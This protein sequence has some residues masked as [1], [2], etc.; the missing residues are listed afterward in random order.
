MNLNPATEF[1]VTLKNGKAVNV[2]WF[3]NYFTDTDHLELRG[4]M[5]STGY[6]SDFLH[7]EHGVELEADSVMEYARQLAQ[8]CWEENTEKYGVQS[9]LF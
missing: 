1:T 3:K 4:S 8:K 2:K 9:S 5:T 7:H 6:R